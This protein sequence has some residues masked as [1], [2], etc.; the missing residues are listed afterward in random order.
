MSATP[1]MPTEFVF[2]YSRAAAKPQLPHLFP[3][4]NQ[5]QASTFLPQVIH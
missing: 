1:Q 4:T 3:R 2:P 5:Q